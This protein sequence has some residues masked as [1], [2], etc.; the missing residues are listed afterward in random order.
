VKTER[1]AVRPLD[2]VMQFGEAAQSGFSPIA[3]ASGSTGTVPSSNIGV[4]PELAELAGA[5]AKA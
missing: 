5:V 4:P 1:G 2:V 3:E